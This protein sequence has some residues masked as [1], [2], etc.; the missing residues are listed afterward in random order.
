MTPDHS[1]QII[2]FPAR[3]LPQPAPDLLSA[4]SHD[5]GAQRL[6]QAAA[7]LQA[8]LAAQR[9]AVA[10]WRES[11]RH[12]R[13]TVTGLHG[14]LTTYAARLDGLQGE[15]RHAGAAFRRLDHWADTVLAPLPQASKPRVISP[16]G[17]AVSI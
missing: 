14:S 8:A 4:P 13:A 2:A 16:D 12:L 9:A 11:L 6:A 3:P 7:A 10:E 5:P 17:S 15:V 1:A